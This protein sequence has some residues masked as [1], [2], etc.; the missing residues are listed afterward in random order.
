MYKIT[1]FDDQGSWSFDIYTGKNVCVSHINLSANVAV[2]FEFSDYPEFCH[3][4]N[5]VLT[6]LSNQKSLSECLVSELIYS[7]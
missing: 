5:N 7:D 3:F 2:T 4:E 1:Y 6:I